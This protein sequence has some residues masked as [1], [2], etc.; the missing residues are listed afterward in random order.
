[1]KF[2]LLVFFFLNDEGARDL[3]CGHLASMGPI[4]ESE[5]GEILASH[6]MSNEKSTLAG[7]GNAYTSDIFFSSWRHQHKAPVG[8][9]IPPNSSFSSG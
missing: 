6:W 9:M 3:Y 4:G 7:S 2:S 8:Y 1:M 5:R